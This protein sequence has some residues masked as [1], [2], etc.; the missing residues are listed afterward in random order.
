MG[1]ETRANAST[2]LADTA[3]WNNV[4][5]AEVGATKFTTGSPEGAPA[6]AA[7][8]SDTAGTVGFAS[9]GDIANANMIV[10]VTRPAYGD[11]A[12]QA[13]QSVGW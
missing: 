2:R 10:T 6:Y 7:A 13:V 8:V 11:F 5:Q 9:A 4:L 12:A 3:A 1:A